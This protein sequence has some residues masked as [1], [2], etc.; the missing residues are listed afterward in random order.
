[1]AFMKAG[2]PSGIL[3]LEGIGAT[4]GNSTPTENNVFVSEINQMR[5]LITETRNI[6]TGYCE[7]RPILKMPEYFK[8][9]FTNVY[10]VLKDIDFSQIIFCKLS[11]Q[12]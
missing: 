8:H 10:S 5:V 9:L 7:F 2:K 3:W 11:D 4:Q 12:T 6:N 1:M